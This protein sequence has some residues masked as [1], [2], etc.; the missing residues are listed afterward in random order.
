MDGLKI[1]LIGMDSAIT[2]FRKLPEN[3]KGPK[4]LVGVL[5]GARIVLNRAK[6]LVPKKTRDLE[7]SLHIGGYSGEAEDI[8]GKVVTDDMV[9]LEVGTLKEYGP[10]EEFGG[11]IT[12]KDAPW[13]VFKTKDGEWH[14]VKSVRILAQP[15]LTPA[16][17]EKGPAVVR[18]ISAALDILIKETF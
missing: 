17:D 18:E 6:E 10:I 11:W 8:G 1:K 3:I 4:I 9:R 14:S 16:F 5:S 13:L 12:T 2:T 15:Y 7:R